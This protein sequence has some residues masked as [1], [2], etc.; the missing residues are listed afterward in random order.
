MKDGTEIKIAKAVR[1]VFDRRYRRKKVTSLT[2]SMVIA[3]LGITSFLYGLRLE[4]IRTIFRWLTVD[5]TLFTTFGAIAFIVV[6]LVEM[7]RDTELTQVTVYYIRLSSAV[8]ESIIFAVVLV[9]QLPVFTEHLPLFD[10]YDSFVMHVLVPLLGILSF[11]I[12]DSP[13]GRL[14]PMKRWHGTW[15]VSCYAVI[16]LTLIGTGLLPSE[17]IPYPFLNYRDNGWGVFFA[18]FVFVY[19]CGYLMAW[20]I[21]E[22]NRTL[23]WLWFK[24]IVQSIRKDAGKEG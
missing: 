13:I 23:S 8:A 6:N 11:L 1:E 5:G 14:R 10:R 7:L 4:S 18:A 24:G 3:V 9:S 15:F 22:G 16:I 2:V 21:S 17:A 20:A 19:G 12:N